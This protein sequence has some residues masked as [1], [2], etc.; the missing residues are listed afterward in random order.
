MSIKEK[1]VFWQILKF[2]D[3]SRTPKSKYLNERLFFLQLKRFVYYTLRV[4]IWQKVVF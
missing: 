4:I 3:L 1:F 2:V